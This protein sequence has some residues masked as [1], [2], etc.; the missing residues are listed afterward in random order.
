M[1]CS[2]GG[3]YIFAFFAFWWKIRICNF[4]GKC[5]LHFWRK[6][7]FAILP[8]N[9]VCSFSREVYAVVKG[10][11]TFFTVLARKC[12]FTVLAGKH[13]WR[14]MFFFC[15]EIFFCGKTRFC[16]FSGKTRFCVLTGKRVFTVL[17]EKQIFGFSEMRFSC[18][19][20][21]MISLV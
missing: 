21:K 15:G 2:F 9:V 19:D 1:F 11:N 10:K 12:V 8:E 18:F 16:S 20:G 17:V 14:K 5:I 4:G 13:I 7:C 6:M 3:K